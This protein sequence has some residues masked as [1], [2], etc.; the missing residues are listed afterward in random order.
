MELPKTTP[1]KLPK[2]E[3][4]ASSAPEAFPA[5]APQLQ[6]GGTDKRTPAKKMLDWLVDNKKSLF[7]LFTSSPSRYESGL[8]V[9]REPDG[10]Y[11]MRLNQKEDWDE[12]CD[13]YEFQL[14]LRRM[15]TGRSIDRHSS[16]ESADDIR[17]VDEIRE[18]ASHRHDAEHRDE[19][20]ILP[21]PQLT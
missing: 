17:Q 15:V 1:D 4:K 21:V 11:I 3:I 8:E 2:V 9:Q 10:S 6:E 5:L 20:S 12:Q 7:P 13:A 16:Q 18:H 14:M 19:I